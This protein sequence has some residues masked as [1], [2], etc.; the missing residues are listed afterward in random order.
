M[1]ADAQE[2]HHFKELFAAPGAKVTRTDEKQI[3]LYGFQAN[4]ECDYFFTL[5]IKPDDRVVFVEEYDYLQLC[6]GERLVRS[7]WYSL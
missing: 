4:T 3:C 7:G 1:S 5:R 6:T 2:N